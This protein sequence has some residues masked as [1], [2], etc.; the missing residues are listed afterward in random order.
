MTLDELKTLITAHDLTY[1]LF[2]NDYMIWEKGDQEYKVI[3]VHYELLTSN[4][5][6]EKIIDHWNLT[7]KEKVNSDIHDMFIWEK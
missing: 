2:A 4:E 6:K 1:E 5:D 3:K 7:V